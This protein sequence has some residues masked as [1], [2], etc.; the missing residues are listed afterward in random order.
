VTHDYIG[1]ERR[2]ALRPGHSA[3]PEIPIP[4]PIR[5]CNTSTQP[6]EYEKAKKKAIETIAMARINSLV[7][8]LDYECN[9]LMKRI[10]EDMG[11]KESTL[12][13]LVKLVNVAAE[14]SEKVKKFQMKSPHKVDAL[15]RRC[16]ELMEQP[17]KVTLPVSRVLFDD[18]QKFIPDYI[19]L[20]DV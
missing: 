14:L 17:E 9:A 2:F 7:N 11:S 1:Y 20:F 13:S 16:Q 3:A 15:R 6:P 8:A 19:R 10:S 12:K 5:A 18:V 4:N